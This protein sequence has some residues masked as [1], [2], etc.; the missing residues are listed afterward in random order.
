[1]RNSGFRQEATSS[2]ANILVKLL[3]ANSAKNL[4]LLRHTL[5]PRR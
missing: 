2:Q 1:M 5:L 3:R 4:G